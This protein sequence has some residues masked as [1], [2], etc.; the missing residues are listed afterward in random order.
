MEVA[1]FPLL[2]KIPY[3]MRL[4]TFQIVVVACQGEDVK[5]GLTQKHWTGLGGGAHA[6]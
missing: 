3:K 1:G 6:K 5:P 2:D 4:Q